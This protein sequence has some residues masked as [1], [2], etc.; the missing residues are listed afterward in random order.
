MAYSQK[1][2]DSRIPSLGLP[3][4]ESGTSTAAV[5]LR[6]QGREVWDDEM[7][8]SWAA[9][10]PDLQEIGRPESPQLEVNVSPFQPEQLPASQSRNNGDMYQCSTGKGVFGLLRSALIAELMAEPRIGEI[11]A[12]HKRRTSARFVPFA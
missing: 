9:L 2:E 7:W 4:R 3:H 5:P 8:Q 11:Q 1:L 12:E 10:P 6:S